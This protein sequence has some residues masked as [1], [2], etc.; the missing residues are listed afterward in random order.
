[1][2]DGGKTVPT[3]SVVKGIKVYINW[4]DHLPPHFHA[5]FAGHDVSIDLE[6]L[7]ARGEFPKRQLRI[8][9]G[10]AECH[11]AELLDNWNLIA[12]KE[13]HYEISPEL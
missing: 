9:L 2:K 4:D 10:W 8:I 13:D 12:A 1:M 7:E 6:T 11:R 5:M 3:L